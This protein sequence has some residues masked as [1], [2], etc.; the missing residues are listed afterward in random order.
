MDCK[1]V[2]MELCTPAHF[3]FMDIEAIE[4]GIVSVYRTMVVC[5]A[6][7]GRMTLV[8]FRL[9]NHKPTGKI[10]LKLSRL[11]FLKYR[12]KNMKA[13]KEDLEIKLE[14]THKLLQG[15]KKKGKVVAELIYLEKQYK[16][17]KGICNMLYRQ[18]R[19]QTP[20]AWKER[21]TPDGWSNPR[22]TELYWRG[23]HDKISCQGYDFRSN[24]KHYA[25]L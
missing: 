14:K 11:N 15:K 5:Y 7:D 13:V 1:Y 2:T 21:S 3:F 24:F 6:L 16:S 22:S 19:L 23:Y 25:W 10:A 17:I 18:I 20:K 8:S 4:E 12:Y 9:T